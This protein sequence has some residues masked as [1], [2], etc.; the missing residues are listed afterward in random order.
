MIT[1]LRS[2]WPIL[3]PPVHRRITISVVISIGLAL[4]DTL[5]VALILPLILLLE[6]NGTVPPRFVGFSHFVGT[7]D[8][9]TLAGVV[10]A[11][12]LVLF[13]T[14]SILSVRFLRWNAGMVLAA[15]TE[16]ASN[17]YRA[18]LYAPYQYHL[19]RNS[20]EL[21]NT[22][23]S[24][25]VRVFAD[26]LVNVMSAMSDAA[27]IVTIA[28]LLAVVNLAMAVT[29]AV[30]FAVVSL[31]YQRLIKRR[32]TRAGQSLVTDTGRMFVLVQQTLSAVKDVIVGHRQEFFAEEFTETST[33]MAS[34]RRSMTVY[35]LL[36]RYYL[37][38]SLVL[39][40]AVI[41]VVV[42]ATEQR[43]GAV[44]TLAVFLTAG[45]RVTP[46]LNRVLAAQSQSHGA[47]GSV[48][49]LRHDL[50]DLP[51]RA[52]ERDESPLSMP[53]RIEFDDVAFTYPGTTAPV[54]RG[55]SLVIEPGETVAMVGLS[56]AGKTTLV[57]VLLGLLDP[58][59]GRLLVGDLPIAEVRRQWQRSVGYVAQ[60]TV[61]L[62][63]TLSGN[64]AFGVPHDEIDTDQLQ[65]AVRLA[66]LEEFVGRL[67][68]G[69]DTKIGEDGVRL[70]GGQRQRVAIARALYGNP[71]VLIFDEATSSLDSE[72]EAQLTETIGSLVGDLT[73]VIVAHRLSTVRDAD[74]IY[75]LKGG[76]V[77]SVGSFS[78]LARDDA[79]FARLVQLGALEEKPADDPHM[80][81]DEAGLP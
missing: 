62:D 34:S 3:S 20:S 24:S 9:D 70:S 35:A 49:E 46:S 55:I 58:D 28:I 60:R 78:E 44:A 51:V 18:Y 52:P 43:N 33:R 37:E 56:G 13:V 64:I 67:P 79:D 72:T 22:I 26:T 39:G 11:F 45:F 54:L 66:Q 76:T 65:R 36:P 12:V 57:D 19:G 50:E 69:L 74:R 7:S 68:E 38:T 63:D 16:T 17:L 61:L 5:G 1:F 15:E 42:F 14:K 4:L 27:M 25:V 59:A 41:A 77:A 8:T 75:F 21:Q 6:A 23:Q 53:S 71:S 30:F 48:A 32:A 29:A 80:V 81:D 73:V 31:G 2:V 47:A 10:G 40:T